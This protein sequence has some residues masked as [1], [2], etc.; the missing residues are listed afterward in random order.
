MLTTVFASFINV[1]LGPID[2]LHDSQ[3]AQIILKLPGL[4]LLLSNFLSVRHLHPFEVFE[5][6]SEMLNA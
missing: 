3:T 5:H 6:Q 1:N 4:Q 2:G